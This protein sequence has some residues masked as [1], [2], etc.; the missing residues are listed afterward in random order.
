[1]NSGR[2]GEEAALEGVLLMPW[3]LT[4][5]IRRVNVL[6]NSASFDGLFAKATSPYI[7]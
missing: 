6:G 2:G 5:R 3:I 1:M 7:A 4:R